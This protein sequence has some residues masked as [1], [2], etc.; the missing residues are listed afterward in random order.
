MIVPIRFLILLGAV[1]FVPVPAAVNIL[2]AETAADEVVL[3]ASESALQ[4]GFRGEPLQ[5]PPGGGGEP[6]R[7]PLEGGAEQ[8]GRRTDRTLGFDQVARRREVELTEGRILDGS[9][10]GALYAFWV[11]PYVTGASHG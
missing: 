1:L 4:N 6:I 9:L 5:T 2:S 7:H 3:F 8:S 11:S 10:N